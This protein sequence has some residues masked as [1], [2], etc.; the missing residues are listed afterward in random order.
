[1]QIYR[2]NLISQR[3]VQRIMPKLRFISGNKYKLAE[4][5]S[6][7]APLGFD[8]VAVSQKIEEIQTKDVT[9]MVTDKCV[10]AYKK[11]G[12][13]LFVEHTGLFMDA[14]NGFPGGL[15]EVF[16]ETLQA[17]LFC[18]LFGG[19]TLTAQTIIGYCDG[20]KIRQYEGKIR[21]T[22]P[23]SPRGDPDFQW[24]C[25][26]IPDGYTETF[27]EMGTRKNDI[28]MRKLALSAFATDLGGRS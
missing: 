2:R 25:V 15:T 20:Q 24:D 12:R 14:L 27:A 11:V 7:L 18:D 4:A 9:A 19:T 28:S 17:R 10:K 16:W 23:K 13:P 6:I 8:I 26:F 3:R 21:G 5:Q 1:M 22:V